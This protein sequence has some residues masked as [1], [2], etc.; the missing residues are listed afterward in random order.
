M[1]EEIAARAGAH[2]YPEGLS[3]GLCGTDPVFNN[4]F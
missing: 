2:F 1:W 3:T 4:N